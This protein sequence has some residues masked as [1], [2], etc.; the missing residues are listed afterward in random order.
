M[1]DAADDAWSAAFD[2]DC[3]EREAVRSVTADCNQCK[4]AGQCPAFEWNDHGL[5]ECAKCGKMTDI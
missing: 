3:D 4:E 1:G 5:L 2:R